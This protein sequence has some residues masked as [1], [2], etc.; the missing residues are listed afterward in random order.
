MN[1]VHM[2]YR[3]AIFDLDGTLIN[4]LEDIA[5]SLNLVLKR[6]GLP[7]RSVDVVREWIG[8]GAT[9][10]IRNAIPPGRLSGLNFIRFIE[11]YRNEYQN[12]CTLK[13]YLYEGIPSLLDDLVVAGIALNVLSNK[14]HRLT[15]QV[16]EYY[17][18]PWHFR[19]ILGQ[20]E[21]VPRKPDPSAAL[22]IAR[23]L[24]LDPSV[25]IYI[26]DSATDI[27]TAK[28]AG[29]ISAAVTWGFRLREEL[30]TGNSDF[31]INSPE[32]LRKIILS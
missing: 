31:I 6:Y 23:K 17:L 12:R 15:R 27:H 30:V 3:A 20:R 25:I 5:D 13:T 26:G 11:E 9:E 10:L 8:E 24:Q 1:P 29:M 16:C 22:E 18:K 21:E 4:S 28:N 2:K 7:Q 32:E 19:N 14:P